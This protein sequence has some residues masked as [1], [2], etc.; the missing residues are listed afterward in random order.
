MPFPKLN[1]AAY[2]MAIN[3]FIK[4]DISGSSAQTSSI[5]E[6]LGWVDEDAKALWSDKTL[7][8][9]NAPMGITPLREE[10]ACWHGVKMQQTLCFAGAVEAVFCLCA[11]LLAADDHVVVMQ[12]GFEPLWAI[13]NALGARVSSLN[14]DY[15][16]TRACWSLDL[17]KLEQVL[18]KTTRLLIINFP[19]NPTGMTVSLD[20]Y[21][22]IIQL[23]DKKGVWILSDEVF[24]GLEHQPQQQLPTLAGLYHRGISISV[25]SKAFGLGGVRVGWAV[26]QDQALLADMLNTKFYLSVCN[27]YTD[28]ILATLALK[29]RKPIL[30]RNLAIIRENLMFLNRFM[31]WHDR[32]F[33]WAAPETGCVAF[34]EVISG[35]HAEHFCESL[36]KKSALKLL[37]GHL[38][39]GEA[40]RFRIGFGNRS[41][42]NN[43]NQLTASI[44]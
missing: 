34:P 7:L 2:H 28:E 6:L 22:E 1:M 31:Q 3:P 33:D 30:Q 9:Y 39:A 20:D 23:A 18:E 24:R 37:P 36:A 5:D 15:S 32:V 38:F 41:F 12:P 40:S 43:L 25:L 8:D 42:K 21:K 13:P 26:S 16:V 17:N 27:G 11:T 29:A 14:L 4:N 44:S 19:H 10:I 35:Q